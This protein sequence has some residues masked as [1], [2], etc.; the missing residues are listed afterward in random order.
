[1]TA[2]PTTALLISTYNWPA[3]LQLCLSSVRQ[4]TALPDEVV[5]A[6]DGSDP[7][8]RM[9]IEQAIAEIPTPILHIWHPDNGFRLAE[10]RNKAIAAAS[11][12][13]LISIDG[14]LVLH[15]EFIRDHLRFRPK[16]AWVQGTRVPLL[17]DKTDA[18]FDH[19]IQWSHWYEL[20]AQKPL[21]IL[22]STLWHRLTTKKRPKYDKPTGCHQAFWRHDL[23]EVNGFDQRFQGWGAEDAD[24]S[25]RLY[26]A[27]IPRVDFRSIAIAMHLYHPPSS[28]DRSDDNH[29]MSREALET[30]RSRAAHGVDRWLDQPIEWHYEHQQATRA[31]ESTP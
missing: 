28:K 13:Y 1:M 26:N 17:A 5:I 2:Q 23:L 10:I 22:R 16:G 19:G 30:R 11:S 6:D 12:D 18:F 24:L 4:Q 25:I 9:V 7:T 27:G 31:S 8:T 3:A 29:A 20:G 15:P 21:K 14:D